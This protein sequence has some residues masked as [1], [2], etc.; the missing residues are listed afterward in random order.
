D[1]HR[2]RLKLMSKGVNLRGTVGFELFSDSDFGMTEF[3]Q[4]INY[5]R[6]MQGELART[7]MALD[8][9]RAARVH[10]VIPESGLLRRG[11]VHGKASVTVT[12]R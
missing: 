1:V 10:L 8:E 5:Q 9:V 6:A 4:K 3:A 2:T 11:D 12:P 7:I